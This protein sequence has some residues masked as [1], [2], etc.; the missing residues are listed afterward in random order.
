MEQ[1]V[2]RAQQSLEDKLSQLLDGEAISLTPYEAAVYGV[3]E[4]DLLPEEE[5]VDDGKWRSSWV[6]GWPC[7][8]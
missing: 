6:L 7:Q 4:S 8:S 1:Y 3:N 5:E 2:K